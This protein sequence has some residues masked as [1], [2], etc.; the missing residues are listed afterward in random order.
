MGGGWWCSAWAG[1]VGSPIPFCSS[2]WVLS[3]HMPPS[4]WGGG[5]SDPLLYFSTKNM[6]WIRMWSRTLLC[7]MEYFRTWQ[8]K[9]MQFIAI[10]MLNLQTKTL[11]IALIHGLFLFFPKSSW[12]SV[13]VT[14]HE[15]VY[16]NLVVM[17]LL[18]WYE[19]CIPIYWKSGTE[20]RACTNTEG[21]CWER[22]AQ[23]VPL[24]YP[25]LIWSTLPWGK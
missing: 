17:Y 15:G 12:V 11:L 14:A 8:K 18:R 4:W 20:T 25:K 13:G 2:C 22:R 3:C 1:D 10:S 6:G 24:W 9:I 7:T 23:P 19:S 16:V 5:C 21:K